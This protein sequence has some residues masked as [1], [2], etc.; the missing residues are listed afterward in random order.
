MSDGFLNC[1]YRWIT[2]RDLTIFE[3]VAF[4]IAI[5]S[6]IIIKLVTGKKPPK[7][8][9][10]SVQ[11][12]NKFT[13]IKTKEEKRAELWRNTM[14]ILVGCGCG[15]AI[16]QTA[17]GT[18]KLGHAIVSKGVSKAT[19]GLSAGTI[20]E[21][22]TFLL[23]AFTWASALMNPP[24]PGTP[25]RDYRLATNWVTGI[26]LGT[27]LLYIV[28]RRRGM[29]NLVADQAMLCVN[30]LAALLNTGL[31]TAAAIEEL[32]DPTWKEYH[33]DASGLACVRNVVEAV[34]AVGYFTAFTFKEKEPT[35][36]T[37]GL[38]CFS[39]AGL[40]LA[41]VKTGEY[42]IKWERELQ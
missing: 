14:T 10:T 39:V 22:V 28:A 19:E 16:V 38:I 4:L 29:E 37:V 3:G 32:S 6:T 12:Y 17:V 18:I 9:S 2:G 21:I 25:G 27:N 34:K 41:V 1:L 20:M 40:S 26:R 8:G 24:L 13:S 42:G 23:D 5:P 31:N 30:L 36:T 7:L 15:I 11:F 33:A 35:T